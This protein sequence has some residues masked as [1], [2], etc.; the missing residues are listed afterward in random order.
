MLNLPTKLPI[1]CSGSHYGW[2]SVCTSSQPLLLLLVRQV[3]VSKLTTRL[4]CARRQVQTASIDYWSCGPSWIIRIDL[5]GLDRTRFRYQWE[6][7][8]SVP[9]RHVDRA[10]DHFLYRLCCW[11]FGDV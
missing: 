3:N 10:E 4:L 8:I 1:C 5:L 7:P 11:R 6:I 9:Q 2:T